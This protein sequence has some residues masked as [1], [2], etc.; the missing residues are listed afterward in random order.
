MWGFNNTLAEAGR[1]LGARY[2]DQHYIWVLYSDGPG[3][4]GRGGYGVTCLPE[5]DLLGLIG[6]H[7]TQ[8]E[9][10]RWVGGLGHEL[11]HAFGLQHPTDTV[12]DADAIMWSGFY[13]KYPDKAYL[14]EQ[15]KKILLRNPFFFDAAGKPVVGKE[16]FTEKYA[17]NGGCFGKLESAGQAEWKEWKTASPENYYFDEIKRD[18]QMIWLKDANRNFITRLPINGG[19]S[20]LST[21]GGTKWQQLYDV[22]KD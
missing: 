21:D 20:T 1:L 17:Y 7:P 12:R 5:D 2:Y 18:G 11:G 15:D 16:T 8:K 3:N 9:P 22:R 13:G 10:S 14:T 19:A 4:K 6:K